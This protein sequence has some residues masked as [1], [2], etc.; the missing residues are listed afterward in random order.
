[1]SGYPVNKFPNFSALFTYINNNWVTNGSDE[2]TAVIGNDVVNG[3]LTFIQQSPINYAKAQII[4][5][6]GIVITAKPVSVIMTLTPTSLAWV[7]NIYNQQIIINTTGGVIELANGF[8]YYD[9][10]LTNQTSIPANTALTIVKATNNQ[11][12]QSNIGGSGGGS[13][14]LPIAGVVGEEG[15]PQV[16]ESIYQDNR[17]KNLGSTNSGNIQFLLSGVIYSN[18]GSNEAFTYDAGTGTIT[19]LYGIFSDGS[20]FSISLNQ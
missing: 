14:K 11:W 16:G 6:G 18:F 3:L 13:D 2:I 1:M 7:D 8:S 12:I 5:S 9:N 15:L 4:S 19:L 10:T 17:I 20:D